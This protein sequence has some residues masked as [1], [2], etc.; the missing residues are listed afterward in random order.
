MKKPVKRKT[1]SPRST[2]REPRKEAVLF[3]YFDPAAKV[4]TL[5]G[6]F[7]QWNPTGKPMKRSPGG[8]WTVT[9]R[10]A[11]DTYQYKFVINGERWEEDPLNLTR[12]GNEHG[13]FNSSIQVGGPPSD[14]EGRR[15]ATPC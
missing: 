10:L 15:S 4:V 3:E 11:P 6:E 8:L 1:S 14:S 12:I 7:N 13:S 2:R 9:M 5:A